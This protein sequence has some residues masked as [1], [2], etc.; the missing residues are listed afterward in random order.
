MKLRYYYMLLGALVMASC[1]KEVTVESPATF[2]VTTEGTSFKAGTP[3]TFKLTGSEVQRIAFY[4]GEPKNDYAFKGGR[5]VDVKGGG[6][7]MTFTSSVTNGAQAADLSALGNQNNQL[8]IL[9]STDFN[10]DY[11]SLA[12][13]KAATWKDITS[14]F[15]LGT[16]TSFV[17][18]GVKDIAD[19]VVPG[20]PLYIAFKYLTKPQATNGIA[21][22]WGIQ[23]F[24]ITSTVKL[25]GTIPI[26][27]ALQEKAA[28]RIVD[29]NPVNAPARSSV[30]LTRITLYGNEYFWPG[31]TL[32]DPA[33]TVFD[34]LNPIYD[35]QSV[36]YVPTAVRPTYKP[37]SASNPWNDPTS[38][39]WAVSRAITIGDQVDLG[40]DLA[41]TVKTITTA[42]PTEFI[43]TTGYAKPGTYKA[44]FVASNASKDD[45]QETT[46]E[47]TLTITP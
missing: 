22:T 44:V 7:T 38:E 40:P 4:S 20:K 15:V 35:P 23:T 36:Y 1:D 47:I 5:V 9:A 8:T 30:S 17:S 33:N 32:F 13:I 46:K 34:P 28:F 29:E 41:K 27:F 12:K 16:T 43:F 11:S 45:F 14:R 18:S 2:N 31:H 6:V 37:Y 42:P 24:A 3:I 26:N 19:L 10:G 25:N 39:N 21:R